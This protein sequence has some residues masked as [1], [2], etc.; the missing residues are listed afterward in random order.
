MNVFS[1]I[2]KQPARNLV[3]LA[4]VSPVGVYLVQK[5]RSWYRLRHF[6]GPLLA[7]L[8]RLWLVRTVSGGKMNVVFYDVNRKYSKFCHQ[9]ELGFL[10]MRC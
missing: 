6:R 3:A 5:F 2:L 1:E 9:I 7:T 4:L 10:S 8:S